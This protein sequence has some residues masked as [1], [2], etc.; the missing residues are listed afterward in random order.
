MASGAYTF[1]NI[2]AGDYTV[3]IS[4]PATG[5]VS[6]GEFTV[7]VDQTTTVG[8]LEITPGSGLVGTV[9]GQITAPSGGDVTDATV[10]LLRPDGTTYDTT[11]PGSSGS[12]TFTDVNPDTYT[13]EIIYPGS[14]VISLSTP[15]IVTADATF[16]ID[17]VT[18][19][20]PPP[21]TTP[22]LAEL[23][24]LS[25]DIAVANGRDPR[26]AGITLLSGTSVVRTTNPDSSGSY[27]FNGITAGNYQI[28]I[29]YSDTRTIR[30]NVRVRSGRT[31]AIPPQIIN[32]P[33]VPTSGRGNIAGLVTYEGGDITQVGITLSDGSGTTTTTSPDADGNYNF[34]NLTVGRYEIIA[35][36]DLANSVMTSVLVEANRTVMAADL[37]L[38]L[39][40]ATLSGKVELLGTGDVESVDVIL[41]KDGSDVESI[42]PGSDGLYVFSEVAP[43]TY[44][45]RFH[46]ANFGD[47]YQ[48]GIVLRVNE[49]R[50]LSDVEMSAD[51]GSAEGSVMI[52]GAGSLGDVEVR[53]RQS[54][55]ELRRTAPNTATGS[56]SFAHL[57]PGT[58]MVAVYYKGV[59]TAASPDFSVVSGSATMVDDLSFSTN[60][61]IKGVVT[62]RGNRR[63]DVSLADVSLRR[64]G[65]TIESTKPDADGNY[66]FTG[67]HPGTYDIVVE[68]GRYIPS[69]DRLRVDRGT[70]HTLD[71][72]LVFGEDDHGSE[73][74]DTI[75]LVLPADSKDFE[76]ERGKIELPDDEDW[77]ALPMRPGFSYL[78]SIEGDT[79][80]D[81]ELVVY[82]SDGETVVARQNNRSG[83]DRDPR[84]RLIAPASELRRV[85]YYL[86]VKAV[87]SEDGSNT[88]S[89]TVKVKELTTI[90]TVD[91]ATG[92][93]SERGEIE[94]PRDSKPYYTELQAGQTYVIYVEGRQRLE[95]SLSYPKFDLYNGDLTTRIDSSDT[96]LTAGLT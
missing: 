38:S 91:P 81:P 30:I 9:T 88:G 65:M 82:E 80:A 51:P 75:S 54:D 10:R 84:L 74:G 50:R 83:D 37:D 17:P 63:H 43:G 57:T 11:N 89:Y 15:V 2:P 16:T 5:L 46:L 49:A 8:E 29:S 19:P 32:A 14:A 59:V 33:P 36:H 85:V 44:Q 4:Y 41:V 7:R 90:L 13:A 24:N 21:T 58:Y 78:V 3:D 77:F 52:D 42:H 56:Y 47:A 66:A 12:Y 94:F 72:E 26:R 67:V 69:E 92:L 27:F 93:G 86:A 61:S 28:E 87:S 1:E 62:L 95:G 55:T 76:P 73:P 96:P 45:L 64:G 35:K 6:S 79:L 22:P 48:H 40:P 60:G 25:G 20:D 39:L 70:S 68:F 34:T 53:L 18:I 23:G 31:T 71:V